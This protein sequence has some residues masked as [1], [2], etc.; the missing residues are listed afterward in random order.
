MAE[1]LLKISADR[2]VRRQSVLGRYARCEVGRLCMLKRFGQ[3]A[4]TVLLASIGTATQALAAPIAFYTTG[5]FGSTGGS[6]VT[7]GTGPNHLHLFFTGA[8]DFITPISSTTPV[9]LSF[10]TMLTESEGTEFVE[11]L[12]GETFTL[13][14]FQTIP[15]AGSGSFVGGIT[16]KIKSTDGSLLIE[17]AAPFSVTIAGITYTLLEGPT[18]VILPPDVL[19]ETTIDGRVT[20][21]PIP[22]VPEPAATVLLGL[23]FLGSAAAAGRRKARG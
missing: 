20:G 19:A 12:P 7:L 21:D 11:P 16:G 3:F 15:G 18:T 10:G 23:G 1:P 8:G 5:T 2:A 6:A 14:I 17:W 4:A 22:S 13:S 9:D